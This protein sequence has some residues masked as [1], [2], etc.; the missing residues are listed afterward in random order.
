MESIQNPSPE[1]LQSM[2]R[3]LSFVPSQNANPQFLSR[4]EIQKYNDVGYL[5]PFD[6][7][8]EDEVNTIRDYFNQI[9]K[10]VIE[11]GDSS[12]SISTA[13]LKYPL[14]YDLLSH[15]KILAPVKDLLGDDIIGWGA[16]FFCKMPNDG[17]RV[18]WHQ[19]CVYW[20]LTPSRTLTVWLAIDDVDESNA[21]MKFIPGSHLDGPREFKNIDDNDAVLS[22]ETQDVDDHKST[23]NVCLKAGQFSIHNDLLLHG[24]EANQS[25]KRRCGLTIRYAAASVNAEFGW[26]Q[27]GIVV[28]GVDR[29]NKWSNLPRPQ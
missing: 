21:C 26:H 11:S 27:K 16:H 3:D 29:L 8:S 22:L 28:S 1:Q 5:M 9:L 4:E 19:D 15:E 24:S 23:A 17:K 2:E 10:K 13:H 18:P 6:G 7:L 12:Y 25:E 20:P 14:I